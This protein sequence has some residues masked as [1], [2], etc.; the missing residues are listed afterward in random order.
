MIW[1]GVHFLKH[2]F[3]EN[4]YPGK[5]TGK[6]QAEFINHFCNYYLYLFHIIRCGGNPALFRFS[7]IE[8]GYSGALDAVFYLLSEYAH[9]VSDLPREVQLYKAL[10]N[11]WS[12]EAILYTVRDTYRDHLHHVLNVCLYGM[13]LIESGYF[14]WIGKEDT[15]PE[16]HRKRVRN[17]IL[18]GLLHD[19]GYT[20]DLHHHL[21]NHIS[22]MKNSIWLKEYYLDLKE[23]IS[24]A[25]EACSE[26][27]DNLLAKPIK[28]NGKLDHGVISAMH[29]A[30]IGQLH[31]GSTEHPDPEWLE[32]ISEAM[33]AMIKHNLKKS[34][35]VK[36]DVTEE[37]LAGLLIICDHLQEWDRPRV[38]SLRLRQYVTSELFSTGGS[39]I[40]KHDIVKF[41][42]CN[43]CWNKNDLRMEHQAPGNELHI[44]I[45]YKDAEQE[46]FEP[47]LTWFANCYD[48][49][50]I[51]FSHWPDD[52]KLTLEVIH[53]YPTKDPERNEFELFRDFIRSK[54]LEPFLSRWINDVLEEQNGYS[55]R[56]DESTENFTILFEKDDNR[57]ANIKKTPSIYK[58]FLLWKAEQ[59]KN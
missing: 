41:L 2:F 34:N 29:L 14:E 5:Y 36:I 54:E 47:A 12:S 43:L 20:A 4:A 33:V 8:T 42:S 15:K 46:K 22:F 3:K 35:G 16:V 55:Y 50:N 7:D 52:F 18:S 10:Q 23:K 1:Y 13:M 17:W 27:L 24:E 6:H 9:E 49:Q 30:S 32:D 40:Q 56:E 44:R 31:L 26:R 57:Y 45:H 11:L 53:P 21:M 37:P 19:I 58:D 25:G 59:H 39:T 51:D 48:F 38:D 28:L